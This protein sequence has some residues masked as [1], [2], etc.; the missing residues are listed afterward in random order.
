MTKEQ[1]IDFAGLI[2]FV[3]VCFLRF[4]I[5]FVSFLPKSIIVLKMLRNT[6][7]MMFVATIEQT[8]IFS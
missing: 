3:F 7:L 8:I 4:L 1:Q 5:L 2:L 6:I